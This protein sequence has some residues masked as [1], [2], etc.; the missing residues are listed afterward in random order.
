MMKRLLHLW[1]LVQQGYP[2]ALFVPFSKYIEPLKKVST[3]KKHQIDCKK[4]SKREFVS[5]ISNLKWV[6][7]IST[8]GMMPYCDLTPVLIR[9]FGLVSIYQK[10]TPKKTKNY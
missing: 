1:V 4:T 6:S 9:K 5:D 8:N 10:K 2:A 7:K 3:V